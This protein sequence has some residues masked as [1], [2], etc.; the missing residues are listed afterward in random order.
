MFGS[1]ITLIDGSA[2]E[3]TKFEGKLEIG[4]EVMLEGNDNKKTDEIR[5]DIDTLISETN[6]LSTSIVAIIGNIE[7]FESDIKR[8]KEIRLEEI[9]NSSFD[10]VDVDIRDLDIGD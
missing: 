10:E 3:L 7:S 8:S 2:Q 6:S 1:I 5:N 4:K 9:K